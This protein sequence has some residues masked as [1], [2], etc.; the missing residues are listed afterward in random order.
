[1]RKVK[2]CAN[3][4]GQSQPTIERNLVM[5]DNI[6]PQTDIEPPTFRLGKAEVEAN[7]SHLMTNKL[8]AALYKTKPKQYEL[9][10]FGARPNST[11]YPND[12]CRAGLFSI[13]QTVKRENFENMEIFSA[14]PTV[15]IFFTGKDLQSTTDERV[16]AQLIY[17]AKDVPLG[18]QVSVRVSDIIKGIGKPC[19]GNYYK[20]VWASLERLY[21]SDIKVIK[22]TKRKI[23]AYIRMIFLHMAIGDNAE[24]DGEIRY[25]LDNS[26]NGWLLLV[27]NNTT[28]LLAND[29]V[30][31]LKPMAFALYKYGM[32][33]KDPLPINIRDLHKICR[34]KA[35]LESPQ[36]LANWRSYVRKAISQ[37]KENKLFSDCYIEN[38][39]IFILR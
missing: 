30:K 5:N 16:W 38:D 13:E 4:L 21:R 11:P 19:N 2:Q 18:E 24:N 7:N 14:D 6:V 12:L 33:H 37:L 15:K 26:F 1:M 3:T 32:S 20:M 25:S 23:V 10:F 28:T 27:A 8:G 35:K 36:D 9:D 34:S 17:L 31:N 29:T 22:G 39:F